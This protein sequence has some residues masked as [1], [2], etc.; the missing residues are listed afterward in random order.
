M[1]NV[2]IVYEPV[3]AIS[4]HSHGQADDPMHAAQMVSFLKAILRHAYK[5]KEPRVLYGGS[6]NQKTVNGFL[7]FEDIDGFLVG[8]ASLKPAEVFG[9]I[10]TIKNNL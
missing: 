1:K 2:I 10:Q 8:A 6:V 9:I 5:V 3:W 4:S 7:S